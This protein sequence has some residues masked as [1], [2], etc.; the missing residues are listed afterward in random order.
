MLNASFF[1]SVN[2]VIISRF[3]FCFLQTIVVVLFKAAGKMWGKIKIAK[4]LFS[5]KYCVFLCMVDNAEWSDV[6]PEWFP[7]F[8]PASASLDSWRHFHR[9]LLH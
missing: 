5:W 9:H 2:A 3:P 8:G 7:G 6:L 4:F 1:T